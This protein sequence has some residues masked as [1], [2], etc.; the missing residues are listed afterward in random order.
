[1]IVLKKNYVYSLAENPAVETQTSQ[2]DHSG[3][4]LAF[5]ILVSRIYISFKTMQ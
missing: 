5:T 3:L 1:M 4:T 2:S